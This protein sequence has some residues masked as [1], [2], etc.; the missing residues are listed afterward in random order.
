MKETALKILLRKENC[1]LKEA[2]TARYWDLLGCLCAN[3]TFPQQKEFATAI[4]AKDFVTLVSLTDEMSTQLYD[5]ALMHFRANQF[6]A[7]VKKYPYPGMDKVYQPERVAFEKFLK[8]EARCRRVNRLFKLRELHGRERDSTLLEEMRTWIQYVIGSA[9]RLSSVWNECRFGPGASIGVNGNATNAARKLCAEHWSVS[10]SALHY[11]HAAV[12]A[13]PFLFRALFPGKWVDDVTA[14]EHW[15]VFMQR[16][17][18][19]THN[20][21]EFVPKT[22]KTKRSIAVEPL[23]NGLVQ[24]GIGEVLRN[25]LKRIN[26]DLT[27][28]SRNAW[29]ARE[30]S[31]HYDSPEGWVTLDLS[32][33]SDSI[34]IGLCRRLLPPE[35]F[36]LLNATR[37]KMF[38]YKGVTRVYEKFCSMGNGFCFPLQTLIF[39]AACKAVGAGTPGI[40]Y[41]VYGDD[42]VVR[43]AFAAPLI[44]ALHRIGFSV[45]RD[46]THVSGKFRESCGGDYFGGVDVNPYTLDEPLDSVQ[47]LFKY[48]NLTR[49]T[50]LVEEFFRPWRDQALRSLKADIRLFR[51]FP[52][53]VDSG[54][55]SSGD[56]H[57][58]AT[59]CRY[60]R[61]NNAWEWLELKSE[62]CVDKL[63]GF[64]G[65][66]Q[67][68]VDMY[69]A[70]AGLKSDKP[71]TYRRETTQR[72]VKCYGAGAISSWAPDPVTMYFT[73]G[74]IAW[75]I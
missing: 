40:D 53:P 45:N 28:Q 63:A 10:P 12:R 51:P 23:G 52:G 16:V 20:K 46:K 38:V 73:G 47:N 19:V 55:D 42:I 4:A 37:S 54:I 13:N 74:N 15:E 43:K 14:D 50:P 62:P 33:A 18:V 29:M 34:A 44:K 59:T 31:I 21:V 60:R 36:A 8:S 75:G 17:S 58:T 39:A 68:C 26:L 3:Q 64:V 24:A 41:R 71:Y 66:Y 32:S 48:L 30:G 67:G 5:D 56:E 70:L 9:P 57:L 61:R 22:V 7:L 72:F 27:D 69:A 49:S 11:F 35:W 6:A 1:K 2:A 65:T 25:R